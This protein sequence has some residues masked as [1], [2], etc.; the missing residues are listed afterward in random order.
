MTTHAQ[1][2]GAPRATIVGGSG[3]FP[4]IVVAQAVNDA[5]RA[6]AALLA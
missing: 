2:N 3:H 1:D 5:I 4:M 6:F